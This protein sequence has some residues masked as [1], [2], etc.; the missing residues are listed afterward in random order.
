MILTSSSL[1]ASYASPGVSK[2]LGQETYN[3][4][5]LSLVE[6][7]PASTSGSDLWRAVYPALKASSE[8]ACWTYMAEEKTGFEF[9]AVLPSVCFGAVLVPPHQGPA[10]TIAWA[11]AAWSGENLHALASVVPP[12]WSV[13]VRDAALLHVAALLKR[14]CVPLFPSSS[15]SSPPPSFVTTNAHSLPPQRIFAFAH[16]F[17]FNSLIASYRALFPDREFPADIEEE[18]E[19]GCEAPRGEAEELLRWVKGSGWDGW[20]GMVGEMGGQIGRGEV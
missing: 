8:K 20:E 10:S 18:A 17:S 5:A 9:Y 6:H 11:K 2:T 1:A 19:D 13:P 7:L 16:R 3:D 12:Q 14:E 4:E 15:S